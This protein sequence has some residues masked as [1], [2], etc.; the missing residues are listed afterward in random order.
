MG[1]SKKDIEEMSDNIYL[2]VKYHI[3]TPIMTRFLMALER[4]W[5]TFMIPAHWLDNVSFKELRN[6]GL[7]CE[8]RPKRN[9]FGQDYYQLYKYKKK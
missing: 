2:A 5:E 8:A 9:F 3:P 4:G 6:I 7:D 1:K